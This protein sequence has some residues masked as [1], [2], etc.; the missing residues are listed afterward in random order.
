MH[1][2]LNAEV[3]RLIDARLASDVERRRTERPAAAASEA[4]TPLAWLVAR[5]SGRPPVMSSAPRRA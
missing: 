5:A 3:A 1:T 2:H 4:R